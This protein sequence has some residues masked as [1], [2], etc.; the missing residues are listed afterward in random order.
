[1]ETERNYPSPGDAIKLTFK[2]RLRIIRT[3]TNVDMDACIES[4]LVASSGDLLTH[5]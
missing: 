5:L 3:S 4:Q 2:I 1:M